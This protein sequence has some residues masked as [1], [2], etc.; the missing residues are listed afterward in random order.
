MTDRK[1]S[2]IVVKFTYCE[3]GLPTGTLDVTVPNHKIKEV[4]ASQDAW[5]AH[6]GHTLNSVT[7]APVRINAEQINKDTVILA[8][9]PR[10][11]KKLFM[12]E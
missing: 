10:G 3:S 8:D 7:I 12:T 11:R 4:R 2:H 1:K 5:L 9:Y 6:K